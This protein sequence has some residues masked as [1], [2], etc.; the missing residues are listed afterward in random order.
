MFTAVWQR[1]DGTPTTVLPPGSEAAAFAPASHRSRASVWLHPITRGK[2]ADTCH[3][4]RSPAICQRYQSAG[5]ATEA[6]QL[7]CLVSP[8]PRA[9]K[10]WGR[11]GSRRRR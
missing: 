4:H 7:H 9:Q 2:M 5:R 1:Q 3:D 8:L 11:G 10:L 6:G